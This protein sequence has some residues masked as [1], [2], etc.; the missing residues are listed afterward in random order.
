MPSTRPLVAKSTL[1]AAP[2]WAAKLVGG[3][4]LW[5]AVAAL[6]F[7]VWTAHAILWLETPVSTLVLVLVAIVFLIG[8]F[9]LCVGW[10]LFLNRPNRYRS[11]LGP[12]GWRILGVIFALTLPLVMFAIVAKYKSNQS[13][14]DFVFGLLSLSFAVVLS[15]L[16]FRYAR[17]LAIRTISD[18]G[19]P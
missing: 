7:L 6:A 2:A 1:P 4:L 9:C 15:W 11:I 19:A 3:V 5:I 17:S 18:R 13:I 12:T 10:R 16:C 8:L 14:P